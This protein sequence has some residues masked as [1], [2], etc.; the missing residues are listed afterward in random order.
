L[1]NETNV[2][3]KKARGGASKPQLGWRGLNADKFLFYF[4]EELEAN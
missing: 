2:N 3:N 4:V 1:R